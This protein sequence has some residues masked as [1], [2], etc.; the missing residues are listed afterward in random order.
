[1]LLRRRFTVQLHKVLLWNR[2]QA[3]EAG[4]IASKSMF[5]F[6][7]GPNE[8]NPLFSSLQLVAARRH[9]LRIDCFGARKPG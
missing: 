6:L 3:I 2:L 8:Q 1:M 7:E 9:C 4:A 5:Y